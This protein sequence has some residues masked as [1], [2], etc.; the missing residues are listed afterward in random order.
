MFSVEFKVLTWR[1]LFS[2]FYTHNTRE[3]CHRQ[4]HLRMGENV[5]RGIYLSSQQNIFIYLFLSY[6]FAESR[7]D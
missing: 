1:I 7:H 4:C 3:S 5:G 6:N 2:E